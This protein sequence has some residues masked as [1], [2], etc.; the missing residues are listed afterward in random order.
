MKIV[1]RADDG[2]E[3]DNQDLCLAY[4]DGPDAFIRQQCIEHLNNHPDLHR[5]PSSDEIADALL[6]KYNITPKEAK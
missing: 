1:Y 6:E 2:T 3:F 4:E 5:D